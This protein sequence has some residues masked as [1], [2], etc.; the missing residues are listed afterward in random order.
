MIFQPCTRI[1]YNG[2]ETRFN[3]GNVV[4][5]TAQRSNPPQSAQDNQL[6]IPISLLL[7]ITNSN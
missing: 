4:S 1:I 2:K 6:P 7:N 5:F 3:I